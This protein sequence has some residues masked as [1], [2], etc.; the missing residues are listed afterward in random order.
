MR[1]L[2]FMKIDYVL[3]RKQM[4]FMPAFFVLARAFGNSVTEGTMSQL[5][6][7][8]YKLFFASKF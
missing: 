4:Y 6:K 7:C 3:T 1:A 8:S 5:V 2:H